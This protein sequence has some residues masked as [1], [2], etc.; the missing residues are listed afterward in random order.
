MKGI[1]VSNIKR[2]PG[3]IFLLLIVFITLFTFITS[4]YQD[5]KSKRNTFFW[6]QSIDT[7]KYSRDVSREKLKDTNF[8]KVIDQQVADIADTGATHV[9]I[10]TPY[11]REFLPILKRWVSAARRYN[12]NVWFRGNWS[13]W[14]GWFDYAKIGR[15]EHIR[16][17]EEFILANKDLFRDGDVFT[18]CPECENG[19][20]GDPRQ[21]GDLQGHRKFLIDEYTVTKRSFSN[22]GKNVQ[23]N[24]N[25]MNGDVANLVMDK[26]TTSA[27]DG[28][29][30]IDHY[31]ASADK[32]VFDIQQ[33]AIKSGG[34]VVLGEYGAPIPDIHGKM[35]EDQQAKWV[36][37]SLEKLINLDEVIGINYWTSVGGSTELWNGKGDE[38]MAVGVLKSIYTP[39]IASG[40]VLNELNEPIFDAKV[41]G[42][43]RIVI[44]DKNGYFS[45]PYLDKNNPISITSKDYKTV[46]MRIS[47]KEM[48]V[49][50]EKNNK[51]LLFQIK[52]ILKNLLSFL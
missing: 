18:A 24:F 1:I 9:A 45:L 48:M 4:G 19:G 13:G 38:K 21:N 52:R 35:T 17:T 16:K 50:M 43:E 27:L 42:V 51:D 46:S 33:L 32:L 44:T 12:L 6:F 47:E 29:V 30:V 2:A 25:S 15:D 20:P 11:D 26:S 36:K 28:V 41:S 5:S 7:M 49:I 34:K 40:K 10:G 39:K 37:D 8:D 14:E 23:S 22:I 31:V 3:I